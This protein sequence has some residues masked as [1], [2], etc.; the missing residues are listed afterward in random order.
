MR[1]DLSTL[2]ADRPPGQTE[3]PS[4]RP[5][6][7]AGTEAET[8]AGT[9]AGTE[10]AAGRAVLGEVRAGGEGGEGF[11]LR[12]GAAAVKVVRASRRSFDEIDDL[13]SAFRPLSP[14]FREP[15]R[16]GRT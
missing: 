1:L 4:G 10:A 8:E 12:V 11:V 16:T 6:S 9:E 2:R 3:R 14:P 7:E 15:P 13:M 5:G